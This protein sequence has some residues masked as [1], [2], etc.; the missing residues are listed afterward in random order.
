MK[1]SGWSP[2]ITESE[3]ERERVCVC[4][5]C[6]WQLTHYFVEKPHI[7]SEVPF[8]KPLKDCTKIAH[9]H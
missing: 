1:L 4:V 2:A 7:L 6:V 3:R 8:I 5:W 9:F